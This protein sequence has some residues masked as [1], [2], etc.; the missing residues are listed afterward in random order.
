M[1]EQLFIHSLF[2]AYQNGI[3]REEKIPYTAGPALT[4]EVLSRLVRDILAGRVT[5]VQLEDETGENSLE[6]DFRDGWA[7]V[8]IVR[9]THHYCEFW[10][11]EAPD[12]EEP[13]NITGDGPT[14]KKH[15]TRNIPLI[16]EI[17]RCFAET[18]QPSEKALWER[19]VH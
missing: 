13:L 5:M 10:N 8:Y 18:G 17:I 9:D 14:P 7:T 3:P 19:S 11:G 15:A 12:D 1:S 2:A 6:A 16:A 4:P